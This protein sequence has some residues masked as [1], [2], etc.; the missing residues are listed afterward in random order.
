MDRM[1]SGFSM[2]KQSD[3]E[4][5]VGQNVW[6]FLVSQTYVP[7][8]LV[9]LLFRLIFTP[10]TAT[11]NIRNTSMAAPM[12]SQNIRG[13]KPAIR[14]WLTAG[15]SAAEGS[16]TN[17]LW[18]PWKAVVTGCA[19]FFFHARRIQSAELVIAKRTW[20]P[21][22]YAPYCHVTMSNMGNSESHVDCFT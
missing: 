11:M 7:A 19:Y 15:F 5:E 17:I 4:H 1:N 9:L 10:N 12:I 3:I 6:P 8:R 13:R 20:M 2:Q 14:A 16:Q 22:N 21:R 18:K